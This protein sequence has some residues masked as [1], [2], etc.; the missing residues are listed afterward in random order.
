MATEIQGIAFLVEDHLDDIGVMD[1]Q[2]VGDGLC[3]SRQTSVIATDK[4]RHLVNQRRSDKRLVALDIHHSVIV[5][6]Y[7]IKSL[8]AA[9]GATAMVG[10]GHHSMTSEA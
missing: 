5:P 7:Q 4:T 6:A 10:T 3:Q 8:K 1:A 2:R 9:V